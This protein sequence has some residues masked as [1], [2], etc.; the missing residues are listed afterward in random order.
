MG[1]VPGEGRSILLDPSRGVVTL[2]EYKICERS[3]LQ[4]R[5]SELATFSQKFVGATH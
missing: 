5:E 4:F 1:I 2:K 3:S